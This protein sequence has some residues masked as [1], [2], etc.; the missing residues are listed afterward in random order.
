MN[1]VII[2]INIDNWFKYFPNKSIK[3]IKYYVNKGE[4]IAIKEFDSIIR[5]NN[6]GLVQKKNIDIGDSVDIFMGDSFT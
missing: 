5:T 3:S 6:L 2:F 1:Q 4:D